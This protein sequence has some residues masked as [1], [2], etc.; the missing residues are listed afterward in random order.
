MK[1]R[2]TKYVTVLWKEGNL[3]EP[4][5]GETPCNYGWLS[6]NEV[7][8]SFQYLFN[9]GNQSEEAAAGEATQLDKG[10]DEEVTDNKILADSVFEPSDSDSEAWPDSDE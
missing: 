10:I 6:D 5:K 9:N 3:E 7:L 4:M 8:Q 1:I 2:H